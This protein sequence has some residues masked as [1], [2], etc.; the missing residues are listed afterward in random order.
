MTD[1][2]PFSPV[3]PP[4]PFALGSD[5]PAPAAHVPV[6]LHP[7]PPLSSSP[8][9]SLSSSPSSQLCL[10]DLETTFPTRTVPS[11]L[12]EF[13]CILVSRSGFYELGSFSSLIRPLTS[14]IDK[15][16]TECNGIT[17]PMLTSAPTFADLAPVIFSLMDGRL[18]AGHN[19]K[20]F[21]MPRL[22][23]AFDRVSH[24]RP[25]CLGAVDTLHLV[26]AHFRDRA[27]TNRMADLSLYFGLGEEKH[28]AVSDCR[29]TL[30]AIKG[31]ALSL[32]LER[33]LPE[34]FPTPVVP[35]RKWAG[36]EVEVKDGEE[37]K[38]EQGKDE[39]VERKEREEKRSGEETPVSTPPVKRGRGRPRKI[40]LPSTPAVESVEGLMESLT[41]TESSTGGRET[42][43]LVAVS[44]VTG[45][46][47]S[48]AVETK[49]V[50]GQS[51]NRNNPALASPSLSACALACWPPG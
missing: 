19:I 4:R 26:R 1:A 18:W 43:T 34:L 30:E 31:V 47:V 50:G 27:G 17:E 14:R 25:T 46:P 33:T 37:V 22:F 5:T 44:A 12:I 32:F 15:R 49:E 6:L 3:T 48:D 51:A 39:A 45:G 16:S 40:P 38:G 9:F 36:Q 13:G 35:P 21:D 20:T 42:T 8:P 11:E 28:R 7:T 2:S 23:D 24:P 41:I 10:F 29:Q